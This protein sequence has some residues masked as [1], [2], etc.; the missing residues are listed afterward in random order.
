MIWWPPEPRYGRRHFT[1]FDSDKAKGFAVVCIVLAFIL[2]AV[3]TILHIRDTLAMQD[4]EQVSGTVTGSFIS[5]EGPTEV[6]VSEIQFEF[7]GQLYTVHH[8]YRRLPVGRPMEMLVDVN[9]PQNAVIAVNSVNLP[10]VLWGIST[11]LGAVAAFWLIIFLVCRKRER[12][13]HT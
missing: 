8:Y 10:D 12:K 7:E 11:F 13:K 2:S 1:G 3:A 9:N 5:G 6:I 4:F